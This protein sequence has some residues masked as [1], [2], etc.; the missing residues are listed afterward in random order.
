MMKINKCVD[1][2]RKEDLLY[3]K[4]DDTSASDK[5]KD[6]GKMTKKK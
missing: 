2:L 4:D 6:D 5:D 3:E 1:M